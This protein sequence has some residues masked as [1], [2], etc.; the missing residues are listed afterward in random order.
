I[1][2]NTLILSVMFLTTPHLAFADAHNDG[3]L[4]Q[5]SWF[6]EGRYQKSLNETDGFFDAATDNTRTVAATGEAFD[7]LDST[8][9]AIGRYFNDGKASLSLG[10]EKF[11]TVNKTY[12]TSTDVLGN[13]TNNAVLPMDVD[14]IMFELSYNVPIS[15]DMFAIGLI[16]LG[17]S[18]ISS[19]QFSI[20]ATTG[21]GIAKEVKNTSSR[22]G[23]GLGY[24][25]SEKVQII[26]LA[27]SSKYGDAQ[28]NTNTVANPVNFNSEVGAIEAS[29]RIRL[30]F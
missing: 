12:A 27:Q 25:V 17:Q 1:S 26:A 15:A 10:Y 28:V 23:L 9:V 19:K 11:G 4:L 24:N 14:N 6:V 16:G 3:G 7:N 22:F 13:V 29:I 30:A 18:T 2:R 5:K 20:G 21:F 8:G